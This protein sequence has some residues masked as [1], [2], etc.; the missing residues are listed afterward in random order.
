MNLDS[1]KL[2]NTPQAS[3]ELIVRIMSRLDK[4]NF[5][6]DESNSDILGD[7]YEYLISQFASGAG[8]K[9]G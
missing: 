2:G 7:A 9:G 8:K 6:L 5:G 4:I 1:S 3:N